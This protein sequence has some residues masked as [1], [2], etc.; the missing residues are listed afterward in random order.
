MWT[1]PIIRVMTAT[2]YPYRDGFNLLKANI[3]NVTFDFDNFES[4][5]S[6]NPCL[7]YEF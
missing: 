6:F 4:L 3:E 1:S 2:I 7:L 5:R